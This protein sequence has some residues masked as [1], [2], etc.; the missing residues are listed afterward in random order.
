MPTERFHG[1]ASL[2]PIN[3]TAPG[4]NGLNTEAEAT[5]LGPEWATVL[6]N[7]KFD[8]AGRAAV[9]KGWSSTTTTPVAGVVMRVHEYIKADGT[10]ETISSTDADIFSTQTT[11]A[12]IEGTLGI[13]EG[14]IKF[15]NFNDKCIAIG[16]GTS[17]NPSVYTGTGNFT[18]ITVNSGT[19]PTGTIGT[20]AFGRL[21]CTDQDGKTIR[22][23]ALLDETRWDTADGGGLFDMSKVWPSGQDEIVAI[24]EFAGDLIIFGKNNVVMVTDGQGSSLGIDPDVM[25]VSDTVPGIGCV[26]QFAVARAAGDLWFLSSSGVQ[27]LNRAMQDKTTPTNN[28]SRNIQS[29]TLEYLTQETDDNNITMMYSPK[30][31]MV[32]MVFPQS[33][34]VIMFD[35]RGQ[36]QDGTYRSSQWNTTLQTAAYFVTDRET[37]GSLTGTVGE[38]MRY[39]GYSDGTASYDFVYQS[40]WLEFGEMNQ[41]LKFVKRLTS[42]MFVGT[43]TNVVFNLF[44][45]FNT[46]AQATTVL[47]GGGAGG[48]EYGESIGN[49]SPADQAGSEFTSDYTTDA[50]RT[51]IGYVTPG[52]STLKESE[53]GGGVS[54]QKLTI[55]GKGGGQYI[56]VGCNLSTANGSFAL[57]QINMYAKVGRIA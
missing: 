24:E 38:I 21:W 44:Y 5:L 33:N 25:Y 30:E 12:S 19:A 54:L 48:A 26:S 4:F 14:N 9:R 56:K 53:F 57:Q 10:S 31:D 11:P 47:A 39:A 43:S 50:G 15:V 51:G 49:G 6:T 16:T 13:T 1:G 3:L 27:T 7:V 55:P 29:T 32:L 18:T 2:V 46:N 37:Y 40:G 23:S 36:M 34:K 22:Y 42:F 28:V 45:D 17:S 20:S 41:Y 52:A 35:T 8:T